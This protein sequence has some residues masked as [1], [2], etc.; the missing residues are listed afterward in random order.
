MEI[1]LRHLPKS[2]QKTDFLI[3][4]MQSDDLAQ[5]L[6][7]E[8]VSY[9]FPWTADQFL[10]EI[11]NP[12]A[13]LDLLWVD[14]ELAGY[15]CFWL[16]A[17]EMQILNLATAPEYRGRGVAACLVEHAFIRC[18]NPGL[19]KAWLEVRQG[20]LAAISLYRHLGFQAAGTRRRYY[21]D[22]ED[23]FLMVKEFASEHS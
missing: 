6:R 12:V 16:I 3:L 19:E 1:R 8:R 5:V 14:K 13:S 23:A 2:M 20:N 15:H 18:R 9:Q 11:E 4:P 10:Q 22:G 17:G 21:Q 7:I